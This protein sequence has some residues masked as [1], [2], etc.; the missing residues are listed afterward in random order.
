VFVARQMGVEQQLDAHVCDPR[1]PAA[2][3]DRA[4]AASRRPLA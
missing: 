3:D 4:P 2:L 1:G